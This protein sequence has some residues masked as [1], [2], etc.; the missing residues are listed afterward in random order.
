MPQVVV[1]GTY[2]WRVLVHEV[3]V[4]VGSDHHGFLI[5]GT[6]PAID[7]VPSLPE[8]TVLQWWAEDGPALAAFLVSTGSQWG[9]FAVLVRVH[10]AEPGQVEEEWEDVVA[11]SVTT[12]EA[13]GIGEIVDSPVGNVPSKAGPHRM[14]L[15]CR[16][17]TESAARD[18][19]VANGEESDGFDEVPLEHYLVELWPAPPAPGEVLRER[20]AYAVSSTSP[21]DPHHPPERDLGLAAA[22]AVVRDLQGVP[23]ARP[24]PGP[25]TTVTVATEVLGTPARVYDVVRHAYAWPPCHASMGS[26]DGGATHYFEATLPEYDDREDVGYIATTPVEATKPR[27]VVMRWNW[28][29]PGLGPLAGRPLLLAEDSTVT[30]TVTSIDGAGEKPRCLVRLVHDGAPGAWAH[31]LE[32]LWRWHLALQA[33]RA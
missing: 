3:S 12:A 5:T 9:P 7:E 19:V 16:G 26:L 24:L 4:E 17:R 10:D 6:A 28:V 15:A 33:A 14:R 30:I 32:Q 29:L 13:V 21:P 23:G 31:D 20:S 27:Q 25:P 18:Y 22:R 2:A 11:V 8:N 1:K